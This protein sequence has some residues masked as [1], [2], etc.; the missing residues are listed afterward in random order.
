[1]TRP[2]PRTAVAVA[3]ALLA[4][5]SLPAAGAAVTDGAGGWTTY[6]ADAANSGYADGQRGPAANV[7]EAWTHQTGDGTVRSAA[8]GDAVFAASGAVAYRLNRTTGDVEW[9]AETASPLVATP[10]VTD[11][12]VFVVDDE[13]VVYGMD[14]ET[15]AVT[16]REDYP[17]RS[18]TPPR[19]T[20]G[21]LYVAYERDGRS[22]VLAVDVATRVPRWERTVDGVPA[23]LAV[24]ADHVYL[25]T[26]DETGDGAVRAFNAGNGSLAWNASVPGPVGEPTVAGD[27]VLVTGDVETVPR[28]Y[29]FDADTGASRWS[30]GLPG[31][32]AASVAVD[33]ARAYVP[34][35]EENGDDAL[36]AV[37]LA[38]GSTAW[39]VGFADLSL[40]TPRVGEESAFVAHTGSVVTGVDKRTGTERWSRAVPG[41]DVALGPVADP[42]LVVGDAG[43]TLTALGGDRA[44]PVPF[45]GP[46]PGVDGQGPPTDPDGDGRFE[47]VDGDGT[48]DFGDAV[49][50]AF[51][52]PGE[53]GPGQ[54]AALDFDSD[55]DVDF[56][57]AISLAFEV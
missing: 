22:H 2:R 37:H 27:R 11:D 46:V 31:D 33:G 13:G 9:R 55:G 54:V 12:R 43:G 18:V 19:V 42:Y 5:L 49:S 48:A 7:T 16:W 23:P 25:Q 30:R 35:R 8:A 29:T 34:V 44:A 51:V 3:F 36:V 40:A 6:A 38:N 21:T 45:D 41:V 20:N 4:V 26:D 56:D 1:M 28:L 39:S 52:R 47:D 24:G 10:A 32:D 17:A 14:R 57:D 15:G 53:L 50:L